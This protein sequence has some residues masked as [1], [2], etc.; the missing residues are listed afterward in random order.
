LQSD[1]T[2]N[3]STSASVARPAFFKTQFR[4]TRHLV[5]CTRVTSVS[6]DDRMRF[7]SYCRISNTMRA[8]RIA[9][10]SATETAQTDE[11]THAME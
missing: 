4:I 6:V 7:D 11:R 3:T 1:T 8:S 9:Q 2:A 10:R 5:G